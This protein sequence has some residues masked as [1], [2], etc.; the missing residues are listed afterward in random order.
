MSQLDLNTIIS[1]VRTNLITANTT[2]GSP[3]DLS[4]NLSKRVA[5]INNY[6]P[7]YIEPG[8]DKM[9]AIHVWLESKDV[10]QR[11]VSINQ[12][13]GRREATLRMKIAGFV[14][15]D[16]FQ[17]QNIIKA[18]E[19]LR[20]LM[21]NIERVIRSDDQFGNTVDRQRITNVTYFDLPYADSVAFKAAVMDIEARKM[22]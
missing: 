19:E 8:R 18:E 22:Y 7:A 17:T 16:T 2:S 21:E 3:I 5:Q 6:S 20:T 10:V 15:M 9:P 13:N 4:A 11:E 14:V 12:T 1:T